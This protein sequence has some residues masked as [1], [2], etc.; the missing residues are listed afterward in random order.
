MSDAGKVLDTLAR[1]QALA[2]KIKR[3]ELLALET[4]NKH[5]SKQ[6]QSFNRLMNHSAS[7][8]KQSSK[9]MNMVEQEVDDIFIRMN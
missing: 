2:K 4:D 6:I 9:I 7:L 1:I 3:L 8:A 5:L